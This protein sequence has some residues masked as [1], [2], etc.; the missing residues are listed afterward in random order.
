MRKFQKLEFRK[1]GNHPT[2]QIFEKM[3]RLNQM[4]LT[5]AIKPNNA[6]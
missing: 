5:L 3:F 2:G 4:P 1:D 6:K